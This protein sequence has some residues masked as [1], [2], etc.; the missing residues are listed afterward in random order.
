MCGEGASL[1]APPPLTGNSSDA[2]SCG[3][4]CNR[5][6]VFRSEVLVSECHL[7]TAYFLFK[8]I[9]VGCPVSK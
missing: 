6:K 3:I 1:H 2:L 8:M 7:L 5:Q 4:V 9:D